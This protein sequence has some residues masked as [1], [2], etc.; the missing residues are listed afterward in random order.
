MR[1]ALAC[2]LA[3]GL[4]P[5]GLTGCTPPNT[6]PGEPPIV[7]EE[8]VPDAQYCARPP[9]KEAFQVAALKS[10][11][12]VTALACDSSEKY[13][14][15]INANRAVLVPQEKTLS[16]YFARYYGRR[17][18]TEHDEYIT[19]LANA[20]SRRRIIDNYRFC[21]DGQQLYADAAAIKSPNDVT[22]LAA[23]RT[24]S[25][26]YNVKVCPDTPAPTPTPVRRQSR[27]AARR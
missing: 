4:I 27:P 19:N 12:M 10:R 11:L 22:V 7:A 21:R 2:L 23:T 24:I 16:S 26:P 15:F 25:Q 1:P 3:L 18:Q 9:E 20:Q 17:A 14:A 8:P 13:N 6:P 5:I